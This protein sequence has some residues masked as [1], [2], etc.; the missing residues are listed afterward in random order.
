M[1]SNMSEMRFIHN[2]EVSPG[3]NI[4]C[5]AIILLIAIT[6]LIAYLL[7]IWVALFK[8]DFQVNS[9][10]TMAGWLGVAGKNDL[11]R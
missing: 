9:Y 1:A 3:I 4:L 6:G 5:G 10:F 8:R 2:S 7:F 11:L